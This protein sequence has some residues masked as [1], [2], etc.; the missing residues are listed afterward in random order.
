[1]EEM[2]YRMSLLTTEARLANKP[3]VYLTQQFTVR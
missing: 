1:M 2:F 3:T